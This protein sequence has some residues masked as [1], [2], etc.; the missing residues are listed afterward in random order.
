MAADRLNQKAQG[1][2]TVSWGCDETVYGVAC[3][4][5]RRIQITPVAASSDVGVVHP[6]TEPH[7]PLAAVKGRFEPWA[8]LQHPAIDRRVVD[9]DATRLSPLFDLAIARWVGHIP[10]YQVSMIS[11]AT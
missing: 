7:R 8:V 3:L 9:D 5:D 11:C 4:I 6:P 2:C 1:R 10:A